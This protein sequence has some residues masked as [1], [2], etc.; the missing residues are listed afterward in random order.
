MILRRASRCV[1]SCL[2][3]LQLAPVAA[4]GQTAEELE[5]LRER[6]VESRERVERHEAQERD[7]FERL[8]AIDRLLAEL[9]EAVRAARAD[10]QRAAAALREIETET[11]RL[12]AELERTRAAMAV[13]AVALYKTGEVGP[14]RVLFESGSLR[15]LLQRVSALRELLAYDATL[16][17][18]YERDAAAYAAAR[19]DAVRAGERHTA[20]VAQLRGDQAALEKEQ[21]GKRSL[22][23]QVRRDRRSER[24]LLVEL[25]RAAR[26]A[27]SRPRSPSSV[28]RAASTPAGSRTR[29]SPSGAASSRCRSM[30]PSSPASAA[31]W[32]RTS[33]RRPCATASTSVR[34]AAPECAPPRG[35]RCGSRAGSA[36]TARS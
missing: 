35:P 26:P 2:L 4:W 3:A 17:N 28:R 20:A 27:R 16:V 5:A 12:A 13:R 30:R 11:K 31:W 19:E 24:E 14:L 32:T 7:V 29:A 1:L 23:E 6:I 34:N 33:S 8:D 15:E 25:E 9:G 36:A 18:R 21:V 10:A 22:L